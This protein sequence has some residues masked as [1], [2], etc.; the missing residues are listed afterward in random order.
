MDEKAENPSD[1]FVMDQKDIDKILNSVNP[2]KAAV[3]F[4]SHTREHYDW[5]GIYLLHE[6][7]L[8]LGPFIGPPTPHTTIPID[9]GICG[10]A[11]REERTINLADVWS[12]DRFIACST[13]T[14]SELVVPIWHEGKVVA[15]I[16]I[17]SN[18]PGAFS[19]EDESLVEQVC[20]L[21]AP[22]IKPLVDKLS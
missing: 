22:Y 13:T 21:V 18:T 9:E 16:D 3:S 19:K 2:P 5:V 12:D 15:E 20:E 4:L 8:V 1:A 14:R 10:A 17:D 7:E 11:V 6:N